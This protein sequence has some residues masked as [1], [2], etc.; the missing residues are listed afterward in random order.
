MIVIGIDPAE[1][2]IKLA[3]GVIYQGDQNF[4]FQNEFADHRRYE[5]FFFPYKLTNISM[6]LV[7]GN[8]NLEKVNVNPS[9]AEDYFTKGFDED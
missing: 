9:F 3:E 6:G 2:M 7:V 8:A 1:H 5:G 4:V